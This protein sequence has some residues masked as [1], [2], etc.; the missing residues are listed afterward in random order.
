MPSK[1]KGRQEI[2]GFFLHLDSIRKASQCINIKPLV[3][4]G[5][6]VLRIS[7]LRWKRR[8]YSKTETRDTRGER[9]QQDRITDTRT[10]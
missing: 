5:G 10:T 6:S 3:S 9:R 7:V 8:Q 4:V 1:K 2:D